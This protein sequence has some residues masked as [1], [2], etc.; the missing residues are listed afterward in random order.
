MLPYVGPILQ[1][2]LLDFYGSPDEVYCTSEQELKMNIKGISSR[3]VQS[4]IQNHS[5]D[6][7]KRI[8]EQCD[9]KNIQ[10]LTITNDNY[11]A[12]AKQCP[13]SP[14]LLYVKGTIKKMENSVAIIGSRRC[15]DYGKRITQQIAEEISKQ[16]IPIISGMAKGIDSYAHTVAIKN[17]GYTIAFLANGVDICYPAEHRLLYERIIENGAVLS[18]YLPGTKAYPKY[19]LERNA[20]ISA[21]AEK[22]IVVEAGEKSGALTTAMLANKY[23]R[24]VYA[25]PSQIDNPNGKGSNLLLE[26]IAKPYLGIKS[27]RLIERNSNK[28]TDFV[29]AALIPDEQENFLLPIEKNLL[30]ILKA[31]PKPVFAIQ[32]LL[33]ISK[34]EIE[35]LLFNLEL[36]R[37]VRVQGEYVLL[38]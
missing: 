1:K 32:D 7:A 31:G 6:E 36:K 27:L 24:E 29:K 30:E 2:K 13:E 4:I 25:V 23:K 33:E 12:I 34:E 38:K 14:I 15:T 19:F 21:W 11:S 18:K 22:L 17:G 35:E 9:N 3:A 10:I 16:N 20:L 8:I 26:S 5:L 28:E 37:K